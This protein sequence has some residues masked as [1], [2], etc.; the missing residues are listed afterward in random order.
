MTEGYLR[1]PLV[2]R[3]CLAVGI[4]FALTQVEDAVDRHRDYAPVAAA[5][6][7]AAEAGRPVTTL[8][9]S[10]AERWTNSDLS[11]DVVGE[12]WGRGNAYYAS[13]YAAVATPDDAGAPSPPGERCYYFPVTGEVRTRLRGAIYV[14]RFCFTGTP[15]SARLVAAGYYSVS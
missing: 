15:P 13:A 4:A 3:V 5:E 1:V 10:V 12:R 8:S 9:Y 14:A 6:A 11:E 7:A 2:F